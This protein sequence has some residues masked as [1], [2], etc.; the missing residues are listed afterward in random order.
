MSLYLDTSVLVAA[1]TNEE[2]TTRMQDW[3][4]AQAPEDLSISDWV[5]TEFSSALS[6]KLRMGQITVTDRANS[7]AMFTRLRTESF[8]VMPVTSQNFRTAARFSDQYA[9]GLR[10]GAALH[11][12]VCADHGATLCTLDRR[13]AEAGPQVGLATTLL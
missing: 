8:G 3:L 1:L 11:L 2:E 9:L 5:V 12:A 6:I 4:G 10:A 7:L 13:L